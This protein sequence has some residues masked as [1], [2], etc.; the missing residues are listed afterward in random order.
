MSV[1]VKQDKL[2]RVVDNLMDFRFLT[3]ARSFYSISEVDQITVMCR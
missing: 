1:G 2:H 3:P